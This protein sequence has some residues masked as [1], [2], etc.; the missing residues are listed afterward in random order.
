MKRTVKEVDR[1]LNQQ[2]P[3]YERYE[4]GFERKLNMRDGSKL[5]ASRTERKKN[6]KE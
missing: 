1:L 3:F 4:S 5:C 2:W 6:A